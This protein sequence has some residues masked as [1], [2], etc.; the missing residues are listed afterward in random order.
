M[1][2]APPYESIFITNV[3]ESSNVQFPVCGCRT[4]E[5]VGID[6]FLKASLEAIT[7]SCA[8][9]ITPRSSDAEKQQPENQYLCR[10]LLG[11]NAF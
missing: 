1:G 5:L 11:P 4:A 3:P 9:H 7:V 8:V 2:A 6:R 10:S